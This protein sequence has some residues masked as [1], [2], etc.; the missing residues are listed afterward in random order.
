METARGIVTES[1]RPGSVTLPPVLSCLPSPCSLSRVLS[2]DA[3]FL[4]KT[5]ANT[6]HRRF[7][8]VVTSFS[9][10]QRRYYSSSI[11]MSDRAYHLAVCY[12]PTQPCVPRRS[13]NRVPALCVHPASP[14]KLAIA[15]E[16][17]C[18]P[19]KPL[20][21]NRLVRVETNF[22]RRRVPDVDGSAV[23]KQIQQTLS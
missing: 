8:A 3:S 12:Q 1:E 9:R 11:W 15:L 23:S 7:G 2:V 21:D 10:G 22:A 18:Q 4:G 13:L 17:T 14:R 5:F 6:Q 19:L 16:H 20:S